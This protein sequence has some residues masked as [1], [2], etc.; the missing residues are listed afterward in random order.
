[1][2][3]LDSRL[4]DFEAPPLWAKR[5]RRQDTMDVTEYNR[6]KMALTN[7]SKWA[8]MDRDSQD[9]ELLMVLE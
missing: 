9:D 6:S 1:M 7:Q 5:R 3:G 4:Y 2:A 8:R